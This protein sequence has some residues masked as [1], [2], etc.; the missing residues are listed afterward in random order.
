MAERTVAVVADSSAGL[1]PLVAA[2]FGVC[3]VPLRIVIG[4]ETYGDTA[5]TPAEVRGAVASKDPVRVEAPHPLAFLTA[6]KDAD[7]AGATEI[8]AVVSRSQVCDVVTAAEAAAD[9][10]PIPVTVVDAGEA[11]LALGLAA[12][13][14]GAVSLEGGDASEVADAARGV[15]L[16]A[17]LWCTVDSLKPLRR[18]G[19]L[20]ELVDAFDGLKG[21]RPIIE[22]SHDSAVD[23]GSA[24]GTKAA[25]AAVL[26]HVDKAA[27]RLE[28]PA[29]ALAAAKGSLERVRLPAAPDLPVLR[30]RPPASHVL[31][32]GPTLFHAVTAEMPPEFFAVHETLAEGVQEMERS[33]ALAS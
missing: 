16:S 6:F 13:A 15:A 2:H 10:S 7:E 18:S 21:A 9:G 19:C 24:Y 33:L 25:R 4:E 27:R 32:L 3:V 23:A 20:P 26:S 22:V 29:V 11:W 31:S 14:A 28:A 30:A 12:V 17:R 5:L 1:D 8:V